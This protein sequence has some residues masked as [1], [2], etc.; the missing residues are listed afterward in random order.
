MPAILKL[1]YNFNPALDISDYDDVTAIDLIHSEFGPDTMRSIVT[2]M[3]DLVNQGHTQWENVRIVLDRPAHTFSIERQF[4]T[5]ALAEQRKTWIESNVPSSTTDV[6]RGPM[7]VTDNA[8]LIPD[9]II[10]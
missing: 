1:S 9:L 4:T 8:T 5:A 6:T 3:D 2:S 10:I 7:I